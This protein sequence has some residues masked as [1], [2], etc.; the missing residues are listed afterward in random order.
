MYYDYPS[1]YSDMLGIYSDAK[2]DRA[3]YWPYI[4]FTVNAPETGEYQITAQIAT[5]DTA[6]TIGMIVDG[7]MYVVDVTTMNG[8]LTE[9]VFLT[10]GEHV[11]IFTPPMPRDMELVPSKDDALYPYIDFKAFKLSNGLS[12]GSKPS[13][14]DIQKAMAVFTRIEAEDIVYA[15][16]NANYAASA[17][18]KYNSRYNNALT[19][20]MGATGAVIDGKVS[21]EERKANTSQTFA[22]LA[23]GLD[24]E[25]TSYVEYS[26]NAHEAGTYVIRVGAYVEGSG[27]MPYGTVLVNGKAYKV[28][29]SGNWNGYDA[30]NLLVELKKGENTIQCVGVTADQTDSNAWIG[31]DYLDIQSGLSA[32]GT[33]ATFIYAGDEAYVTFNKYQD[34]GDTLSSGKFD[35]LRWD[36]LSVDILNYAYLDRIPYAAIKVTAEKDGEYDIY[37]TTQ[38]NAATTSQQIGVLV[39][40]VTA[41][42]VN[43]SEFRSHASVCLTEGTHILVFTSPMPADMKT[44]AMTAKFDTAAYPWMKSLHRF[45][46]NFDHKEGQ[47]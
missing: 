15:T 29:F 23:Q 4:A 26:V 1:L 17:E 32:N 13:D 24:A 22:Q 7:A 33:G 6:K 42:P 41:Y 35:D 31:Y 46:R 3:G 18:K 20:V 5:I 10:K 19:M 34:K 39:D 45:A 9:S 25:V 37:F 47:L 43:L 28:Q 44:A 14:S 30:V 16:Y 11:I 21:A 12:F 40:G 2:P 8:N 27:T 38:F 36:R